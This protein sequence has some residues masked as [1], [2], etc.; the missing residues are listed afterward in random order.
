LHP[1]CTEFP[2]SAL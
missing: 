1:D 2:C